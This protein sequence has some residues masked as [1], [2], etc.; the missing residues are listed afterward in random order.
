MDAEKRAN[1]GYRAFFANGTN[2]TRVLVLF[3]WEVLLEWAASLRA[4]R[5]D[6]QP[7]GHRGGRYPFLRAGICV[8]VRDLIVFGV[9]SDMMRG[10]PAIYAT[11]SSYDEVAHH[12]GLERADTMEA[13]RK[14]DG[15]FARIDRARR[16]APRPY[17]IVVLSDHG[18]TQGAT[19]LQRNGYTLADLVDRT[20]ER[21]EVARLAAGDEHDSAM[22]QAVREA[23]GRPAPAAGGEPDT[24]L[25]AT[26]VVVLG[27]GN[28]G[29]IYLMD[30]ERR[31]T[32]EEIDERYPRL[33]ETLRRHPHVGFV[34]ARSQRGPVALGADG[35][36]YVAE[37]A[38]DGDDPLARFAPNAARHLLRTDGFPHAP[39]LMV[40][41]FYD[42][43]LEQGC[44]FEEL[45]SFHGGMGGPQT[46]A[47]LLAPAGLPIPEG[48]IV[49]AERVHDIL[50]GWRRALQGDAPRAPEGGAPEAV[51]AAGRL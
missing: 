16:Y 13:L 12:S 22:S 15:A 47:F 24:D 7:R 23:T 32:L 4:I 18:Q 8:V 50:V 26:R 39:D 17:Q 6:V 37:G 45:I 2:V 42:A 21:G 44:A 51:P 48:E 11:F 41:S 38:V 25:D 3:I 43:Q 28:L 34:L 19:F 36:H 49:G 29:L 10:R 33:V 5:R 35:A 9:L 31:L 30:E 27:S 46:R 20:I 14:L 1:P 40:N